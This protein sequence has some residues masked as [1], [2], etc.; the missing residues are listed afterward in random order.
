MVSEAAEHYVC[1]CCR[2][3][4]RDAVLLPCC[5]ESACDGCARSCRE[6]RAVPA[7]PGGVTRSDRLVR[8]S[9]SSASCCGHGIAEWGRRERTSS[10][11]SAT[12]PSSSSRRRATR[13]GA[14]RSLGVDAELIWV[15][16]RAAAR[17][18]RRPT[19]TTTSAATSSRP[20]APTPA[21]EAPVPAP[22]AAPAAGAAA[23][24]RAA[25]AG[26][27]AGAAAGARVAARGA[28]QYGGA[29]YGYPPNGCA[30]AARAALCLGHAR[31]AALLRAFRP[32]RPGPQ[33]AR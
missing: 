18:R 23:R 31:G 8:E 26:R 3:L 29:P 12:W 32:A 10:R 27:G 30:A 5:G 25:A 2:G 17:L 20:A 1:R 14:A 24:R 19:T 11:S 13:A 16:Q 4:L 7:L 28:G 21:P 15:A 22:A 6:R 9:I 33:L